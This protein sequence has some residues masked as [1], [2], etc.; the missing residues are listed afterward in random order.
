MKSKIVISRY[1]KLKEGL[2]FN[3]AHAVNG[4]TFECIEH[5]GHNF[6]ATERDYYF[7]KSG[8]C[9]IH[10]HTMSAENSSADWYKDFYVEIEDG[11]YVHAF[12]ATNNNVS[13]KIAYIATKYSAILKKNPLI[14]VEVKSKM[15][16]IDNKNP[17][18][19]ADLIRNAEA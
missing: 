2:H 4:S 9:K 3:W 13:E 6:V 1:H 15:I 19:L 11:V 5:G 7:A 14:Q 12:I 17:P 18:K 10:Y 16:F 8:D